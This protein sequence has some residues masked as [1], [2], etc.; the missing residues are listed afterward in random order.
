MRGKNICFVNSVKTWGGGEKWHYE[1]ASSL[2]SSEYNV[3]FIVRRNSVLY[4]KLRTTNIPVKCVAINNFSFLNV[5]KILRIVLF[6]R[7]NRIDTV[8]M[9][10]SADVKT[11]GIASKIAG[12]RRIIYR[13]GS[14][15][16]IRNNYVN[17]ILFRR[18]L[19]D[20][21]AN[22][23]ATK[24]TIVH[25]NI[26]IFPKERIRVIY[27]G[28]QFKDYA[29][30]AV[31]IK[32]PFD[33]EGFVVLGNLGRLV[34]QKGQDYL[35]D[36]A[37]ILKTK[38]VPF[39]IVVGGTGSEEDMLRKRISA[40]G[41]D[42][43]I[44][45]LG[46]INDVPGFMASIDIFLLPSRWEGFGFVLAEAMCYRKPIVAWNISSNTELVVHGMNGYLVSPFDVEAFAHH[47]FD[48]IVSPEKRLQFGQY[49]YDSAMSKFSFDR[50]MEDL[51]L[52]L[53]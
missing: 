3:F 34:H 11:V 16:P 25:N 9:N 42:R 39:K 32:L 41:L 18:V 14:A 24:D 49:G 15:I 28:L 7:L 2:S 48:I 21:I 17:R 22:S 36:I 33:R 52:F 6:L 35:V 20:V 19:T 46:F 13:R 4:E 47:V 38:N 45:L 40:E 50:M 43:D 29:K 37:K 26:N 53:D 10:F 23:N 51:K 8:I 30:D 1:A 27:N 12:V 44:F 31:P 5:F